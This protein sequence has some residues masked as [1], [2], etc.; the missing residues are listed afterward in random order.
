MM[1][2]AELLGN[3]RARRNFVTRDPFLLWNDAETS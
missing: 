3:V 2:S 1:R